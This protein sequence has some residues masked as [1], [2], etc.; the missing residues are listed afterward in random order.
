MPPFQKTAFEDVLH[1]AARQYGKD[2]DPTNTY[3]SAT[4]S[5]KTGA[6][7]AEKTNTQV[8]F[9]DL[10]LLS[11]R[12][13][14]DADGVQVEHYYELQFLKVL[15]SEIVPDNLRGSAQIADITS[16][17]RELWSVVSR[18]SKLYTASAHLHKPSSNADG[19][20]V[21][22]PNDVHADKNKF[23]TAST[24]TFTSSPPIKP[25]HTNLVVDPLLPQPNQ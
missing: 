4:K 22:T 12:S 16:F 10:G 19:N 5:L 15:F 13:V 24:S 3:I 1:A 8:G 14:I 2:A 9:S 25:T 23:F 20:L 6:T 7:A 11:A 18:R 17:V 21:H